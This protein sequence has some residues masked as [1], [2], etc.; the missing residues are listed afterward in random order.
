MNDRQRIGQQILNICVGA[1]GEEALLAQIDA[2][3]TG[4]G[5]MHHLNGCSLAEAEAVATE[6]HEKIIAHI[7]ANWGRIEVAQ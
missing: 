7:R 1:R 5:A 4:I 6:A 2:L 3:A